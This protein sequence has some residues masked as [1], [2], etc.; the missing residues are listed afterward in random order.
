MKERLQMALV[1]ES[2]EDHLALEV[3][4]LPPKSNYIDFMKEVLDTKV[5]LTHTIIL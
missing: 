1:P 2:T 4:I 5:N 3:V